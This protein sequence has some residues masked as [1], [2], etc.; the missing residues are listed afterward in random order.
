MRFYFFRKRNT[1]Y[2][3][4]FP[5]TAPLFGKSFPGIKS[6]LTSLSFSR[7]KHMKK[8]ISFSL[9]RLKTQ[10][11]VC[12]PTTGAP[13]LFLRRYTFAHF[14]STAKPFHSRSAPEPLNSR[15]SA[16]KSLL[17]RFS[18]RNPRPVSVFQNLSELLKYELGALL[19]YHAR[20]VHFTEQYLGL[21]NLLAPQNKH[22]FITKL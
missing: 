19:A 20:F 8:S 18:Q 1:S 12:S 15:C 4:F 16:P 2:R 3:D 5:M 13:R 14:T 10:T 9:P 7:Q 22:F 11:P 6:V 17:A 21:L